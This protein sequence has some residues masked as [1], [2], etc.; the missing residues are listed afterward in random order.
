MAAASK[1]AV[2]QT[3]S[4]S[5]RVLKAEAYVVDE[6][7][8]LFA[9]SDERDVL[10]EECLAQVR[11]AKQA[12]DA[13]IARRLVDLLQFC[14]L[15]DVSSDECLDVAAERFAALVDPPHGSSEPKEGH[16]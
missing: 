11:K 7:L 12:P 8:R 10:L 4:K 1:N 16:S 14:H 3:S 6:F 13:L 9:L 5:V 15:Q 2:A